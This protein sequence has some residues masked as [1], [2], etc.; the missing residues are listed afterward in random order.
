MASLCAAQSY[1]KQKKLLHFYLFPPSHFNRAK[2]VRKP[3]IPRIKLDQCPE[4]IYL[5]ES[6]LKTKTSTLLH[7]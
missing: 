7:V 5:Q 3:R 1:E 4:I 2:Y 6:P